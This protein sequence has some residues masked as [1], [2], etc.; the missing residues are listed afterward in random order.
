[1]KKITVLTIALLYTV[2]AYSQNTYKAVIKDAKTSE[3]LIGATASLQGTAIGASSDTGGLVIL[4]KIPNGKQII[5]FSYVGY[6][7]RLDTIAFPLAQN[8]PMLILLQAVGKGE[9]EELDAVVIGATRSSRTI[10]NIPTRVEVIAGDE[11]DEKGNMKP[12]D[13]RMMLAESTGIQTQQ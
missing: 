12:G 4:T 2:V 13:I 5:R 7:T 8:S 9:G 1:M 11:L 6:E 3:M 10:A